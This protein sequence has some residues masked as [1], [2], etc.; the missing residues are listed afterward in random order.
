MTQYFILINSTKASN[1][2]LLLQPQDVY[3]SPQDDYMLHQDDYMLHQ[4]DYI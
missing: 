3:I 2:A 4:D 1:P